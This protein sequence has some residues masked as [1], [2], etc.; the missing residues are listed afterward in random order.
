MSSFP[1]ADMPHAR[2]RQPSPP[3]IPPPS[4]RP[5]QLLSPRN[6]SHVRS[7]RSS[8]S[9]TVNR[10]RFLPLSPSTN[11]VRGVSAIHRRESRPLASSS[12]LQPRETVSASSCSQ[13]P[14]T[15]SRNPSREKLRPLPLL[16]PCSLHHES[17]PLPRITSA[18]LLSK[19]FFALR[20]DPQIPHLRSDWIDRRNPCSLLALR[21]D[22][23]VILMASPPQPKQLVLATSSTDP[24]LA[25]LDPR[26]G[27]EDSSTDLGPAAWD[28]R[29]RCGG[30]LPPP[31]RFPPSVARLSCRP[32]P[33]HHSGFSRWP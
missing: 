32:L 17:R 13:H 23:Q 22:H 9:I 31:L 27:V 11:R 30:H 29:T 10:V 8:Q 19:V 18:S 20:R 3:G 1:A 7:D 5:H 16:I 26:T 12:S 25:A 6:P 15:A 33:R 28:L 21:P 4:P 14:R 2:A 24:E